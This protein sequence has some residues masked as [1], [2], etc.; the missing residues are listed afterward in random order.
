VNGIAAASTILGRD[1]ARDPDPGVHPP[2]GAPR[3][4]ANTSPRWCRP[5]GTRSSPSDSGIRRSKGRDEAAAS[6][7]THPRAGPRHATLH[8]RGRS[9][10]TK[11]SPTT[12]KAS[13]RQ[14][15]KRDSSRSRR[16]VRMVAGPRRRAAPPA[17][18]AASKPPKR[19]EGGR[20]SGGSPTT[21]AGGGRRRSEGRSRRRPSVLH[22]ARPT[23]R[24]AT[25]AVQVA[26]LP[27]TARRGPGV[28][29]AVWVSQADLGPVHRP[30]GRCLPS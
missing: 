27:I 1:G 18:S 7:R 2:T 12:G 25:A 8:G 14:G 28:S 5:S 20:G 13:G 3:R 17:T 24:R 15:E 11:T 22:Q 6:P 4:P 16:H 26:V 30:V 9:R 21:Q 23:E 29:S 10:S 19:P